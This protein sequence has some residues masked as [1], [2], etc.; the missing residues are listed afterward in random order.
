MNQRNIELEN[1]MFDL[2]NSYDKIK[3]LMI[4]K[5]I[6]FNNDR[7]DD[8]RMIVTQCHVYDI[9]FILQTYVNNNCDLVN[10][11]VRLN[12]EQQNETETTITFNANYHHHNQHYF[13]NS[14]IFVPS[15]ETFD[16]NQFQFNQIM[17]DNVNYTQNYRHIY[18]DSYVVD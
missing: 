2:I 5:N 8:L 12:T 15:S 14:D 6:E 7:I 4:E 18:D 1:N 10:T 11:I 16:I 17:S 13:E 3:P 9:D